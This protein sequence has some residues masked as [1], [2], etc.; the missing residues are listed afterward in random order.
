M[1]DNW[2][3]RNLGRAARAGA[4]VG[5]AASDV[6]ETISQQPENFQQLG[7]AGLEL[8]QTVGEISLNVAQSTVETAQEMGQGAVDASLLAT[9]AA[10]MGLDSVATQAADAL[11]EKPSSVFDASSEQVVLRIGIKV[12]VIF[13]IVFGTGVGAYEL[14]FHNGSS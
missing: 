12:V 14:C 6:A 2:L 4:A 5:T 8:G 3:F 7:R 9:E 10:V 11:V 1:G 13:G